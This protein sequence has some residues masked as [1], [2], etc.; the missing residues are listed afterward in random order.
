MKNYIIQISSLFF[1]V[2]LLASNTINLHVYFHEQE[3]SHCQDDN[4]NHNGD[5]NEEE[6]PCDICLIAF[7]LTNLD[8]NN[9]PVFSFKKL[10][11]TQQIPENK[12]F[13]YVETLHKQSYLNKNRNKAPPY[14]A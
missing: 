13:G 6:T 1:L 8:Y 10:T 3:L 12:I 5:E 14:L 11:K 9:T 7:N 2:V 4:T